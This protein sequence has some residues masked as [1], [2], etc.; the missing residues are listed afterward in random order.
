MYLNDYIL[1]PAYHLTLNQGLYMCKKII[2]MMAF[3]FSFMIN[4]AVFAM[5]CGQGLKTMVQSLNLTDDQKEKI[6]PILDQLK[7][8]VSSAASQMDDLSNQIKQQVNS[9]DM[10]QSTV[11][12]LV[13]KKTKLMGDMMKAK[14]TAKHQVM[15]ILTPEQKTKLQNMFKKMENKMAEKYK[16]CH[17]DD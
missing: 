6:K 1:N 17:E 3:L 2:W 15:N 7:S 8:S 9:A 11:D 14:I 5:D 13:D 12:G 10:D 4:Q 16:K